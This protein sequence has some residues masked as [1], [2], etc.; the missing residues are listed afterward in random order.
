MVSSWLV[1]NQL[2]H[3]DGG[4]LRPFGVSS[5]RDGALAA[6]IRT[7]EQ[8]GIAL[9]KGSARTARVNAVLKTMI[10]DGTIAGLQRLW[11]DVDLTKV[12]AP[13]LTGG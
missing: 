3:T 1:A 7:G 13:A 8:Y 4:S 5:R 12:R 11:L 6:S 9:S 2:G 10:D